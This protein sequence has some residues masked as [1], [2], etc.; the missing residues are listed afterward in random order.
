MCEE[1]SRARRRDVGKAGEPREGPAC[2]AYVSKAASSWRESVVRKARAVERAGGGREVGT[3][4]II[5]GRLIVGW[6][7]GP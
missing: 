3:G 5:D 4:S 6:D 1:E 7:E 2:L